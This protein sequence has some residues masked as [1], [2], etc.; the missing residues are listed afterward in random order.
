MLCPG[1]NCSAVP[2]DQ[3]AQSERL[4]QLQIGA[5]PRPPGAVA[6]VTQELVHLA[7]QFI[8]PLE[9]ALQRIGVILLTN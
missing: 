9:G 4:P 7:L 3:P 2:D 5:H 6:P 8:H 1:G